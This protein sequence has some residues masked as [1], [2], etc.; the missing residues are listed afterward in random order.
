MRN[1]DKSREPIQQDTLAELMEL[2]RQFAVVDSLMGKIL[3]QIASSGDASPLCDLSL[4]EIHFLAAVAEP[5]PINGVA[6]TQKIGL[7]KGGVSKMAARL[8]AKGMI[9]TERMKGNRKS[10]YY[11]LTEK[12]G[13]ASKIHNA[14][15]SIAKDK[16][17]GSLAQ[18]D[19]DQL[20][21]FNDML[22]RI[23][24]AIEDSSSDI[25]ANLKRYLD[26]NDIAIDRS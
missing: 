4:A 24:A 19:V 21:T 10:Q 8:S 15:H 12:G 16:I 2:T 7:T 9:E 13:L 1:T 20:T 18:Y 3:K 5:P 6:L 23:S 22:H 14:L 25:H 26:D 11:V 17:I